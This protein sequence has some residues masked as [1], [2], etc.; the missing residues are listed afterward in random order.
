[1]Q[2]LLSN[3]TDWSSHLSFGSDYPVT[4]SDDTESD[5]IRDLLSQ[6][7]NKICVDCSKEDPTFASV[8]YGIFMC[9]LCSRKH[10]C[11]HTSLYSSGVFCVDGHCWS[12]IEMKKMEVGGNERINAFLS[13]RG[14]PKETDIFAKYNT[15]AAA[16][17]R[18]RIEALAGGKAW[19]DPPVTKEMIYCLSNYLREPFISFDD[20]PDDTGK[21]IVQSDSMK[22]PLPLCD[23]RLGDLLS[24]S[25]NK[26][27]VDC[28]KKNPLFAS[29]SYGIFM[30]M[31]CSRKHHCLHTSLYS[32]GVFCVDGHCWSEIEMK[33]ME[34][35]GNEHL[36]A[37]LSQRGIPKETDI[38]AKYNTKAATV[39]RDRIE[40]LAGGKAW[41]DP[42]VTKE[43][44]YCLSDYLHDPLIS[45]DD[46]DDTGIVQSDSMK[47][48]LPL[49]DLRLG[50]LLSQPAN[51]ICVDCS[52]KNPIFVSV[53]YGIFMCM[54]CSRKH[55]CLHTP[56]Y[57]STSLYS[58]G[59][60]CMDGHCWSEIEM[61]KME[62]GGNEHLNAFLSQRGI[63]KETDIFAKYNTK[64]A[65][66]YFDRIEALAG[67]KA[68]HDP[69]ATKEKIVCIPDHP[70]EPFISFDDTDDTGIVQS[71]SM[72]VPLPLCDLRLG[73]LLS[74]PANKICVD[75]SKKN[76]TFVSVSYGIFMC[77]ACSR[78]H[79]CL[80]TPLYS[81]T[82]LYSSGVFCVDGHCWSEIEMKKME[83]GGNEHLNAFL[84][85]RGIPKETDIFAKYNTNAATVYFDRIEALAGGKAWHD[86]PATKEMFYCLSDH[87]CEPLISFDDSDD[88]G[89]IIVQSDSMKVPLPI[90]DLRFGHLQ[91]QPANKICVDCSKKNPTFASVPYGI[92]MCFDCSRKHRCLHPSLYLS[93][94]FYVDWHCW[95]E[96]E[97]RKM[98]VGGNEHLN[99]FLSQRGI[100]KETDILVKYKTEAA[101][102][103]RD[104]IQALAE[105]K[106]WHDIPMTTETMGGSNDGKRP[107][108]NSGWNGWGNADAFRSSHGIGRT[109]N[110]TA[111]DMRSQWEASDASARRMAENESGSDGIPPTAASKITD[112]VSVV[113]EG[114]GKPYLDGVVQ[115]GTKEIS[116]SK[117]KEGG[118]DESDTK[119]GGW[120]PVVESGFRPKEVHN[121]WPSQ[122]GVRKLVK[123]LSL[124]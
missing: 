111:V 6:P 83:V 42:P 61:K 57:S 70:H 21:I 33:K 88:T 121:Q 10:S 12:E 5:S 59:V 84:S 116:S 104:R 110:H 106:A 9:M 107:K 53:S 40:A 93:G 24:Q 41:H 122:K 94:V 39:Y 68:W 28:S 51:K 13:Q 77:M 34:V 7:G 113:S 64:A 95:S 31:P 16:V 90:S 17:Y 112:T 71:D 8:S 81:S 85:Q 54:P 100:P 29:V 49:C 76:P 43:M 72:K 32:S 1:M 124:F 47:V 114:N 22:V 11:L 109:R 25:A 97:I 123:G 60:F 103:Y 96:I 115:A 69:P 52:T 58:S 78:K 63:P 38:F 35:G 30:C 14:I 18:D 20:D 55:L 19:H 92:F 74:Q 120:Q 102:V 79:R 50:D 44:I 101:A 86:P 62:V 89:R 118:Y 56:L 2:E 73:D 3:Q 65:E 45:F 117:V 87:L 66:V 75:C 108:D 80:H 15:K 26:I 23:L 119:D 36:N 98:E 37:F 91:S 99:A 67:G 27:C 4:S 82:S 46:T 48:P 105:G